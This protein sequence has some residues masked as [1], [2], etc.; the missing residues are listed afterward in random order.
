MRR[1]G[2]L[3]T[4]VLSGGKKTERG[5]R[6]CRE[7]RRARGEGACRGARRDS[8]REQGSKRLARTE[9]GSGLEMKRIPNNPI[10]TKSKKHIIN[11][12]VISKIYHKCKTNACII[13]I[14]YFNSSVVLNISNIYCE[15]VLKLPAHTPLLVKRKIHQKNSTI[16]TYFE[17]FVNISC[18][19]NSIGSI[20]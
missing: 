5:G 3:R 6:S 17:L 2:R 10:A 11:M 16:C 19:L 12:R 20:I 8:S 7:P 18:L 9:S 1:H 14:L 13:G 15:K 4:S